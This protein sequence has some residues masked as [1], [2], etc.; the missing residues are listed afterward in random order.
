MSDKKVIVDTINKISKHYDISPVIVTNIYKEWFIKWLD[1]KF[2]WINTLEVD[3][4]LDNIIYQKKFNN[5]FLFN[6]KYMVS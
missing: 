6:Y 5:F 4:E 2:L 1:T 3:K